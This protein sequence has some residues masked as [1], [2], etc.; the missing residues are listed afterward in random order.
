MNFDVPLRR[1]KKSDCG[2]AKAYTD[3]PNGTEPL[4]IHVRER[5][6]TLSVAPHGYEVTGTWADELLQSGSGEFGTRGWRCSR[7][8]SGG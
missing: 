2:N 5:A 4:S 8:G 7:V 3:Q 1:V 6:Y